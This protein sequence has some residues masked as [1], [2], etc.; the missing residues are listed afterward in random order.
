MRCGLSCTSRA[1]RCAYRRN[2]GSGLYGSNWMQGF[3]ICNNPKTGQRFAVRFL[4]HCL[5]ATHNSSCAL[6][7]ASFRYRCQSGRFACSICDMKKLL[8]LAGSIEE[9]PH[10]YP[11]PKYRPFVSLPIIANAAEE[12]AS[13][14]DFHENP[15]EGTSTCASIWQTARVPSNRNCL[16]AS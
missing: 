5:E 7:N 10:W 15:I 3:P 13:G 8:R 2:I 1:Y 11:H 14:S 12:V 4:T 16:A 6:A 9:A